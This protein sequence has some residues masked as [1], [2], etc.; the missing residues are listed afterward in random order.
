VGF[1]AL[2]ARKLGFTVTVIESACRAID[3][4]G[5]LARMKEEW[6]RSG[7]KIEVGNP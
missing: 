6:T 3:L 2:D 1:S 5:S 4:E 7:V